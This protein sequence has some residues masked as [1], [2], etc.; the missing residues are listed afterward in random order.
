MVESV[1]RTLKRLSAD[2]D[3]PDRSARPGLLLEYVSTDWSPRVHP[4]YT[5]A[6][7]WARTCT[8]TRSNTL[9]TGRE[10]NKCV[11]MDMCSRGHIRF[12]S[13][14]FLV[15]RW[16]R[17]FP[18]SLYVSTSYSAAILLL[19]RS[20]SIFLKETT[21]DFGDI[22]SVSY[23]HR[24]AKPSFRWQLI[25]YYAH[26]SLSLSHVFI[27]ALS[28]SDSLMPPSFASRALR[29]LTFDRKSRIND[30]SV[31]QAPV[32][33]LHASSSSRIYLIHTPSSILFFSASLL[34][35]LW[36]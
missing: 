5:Q 15:C 6:L 21:G 9:R 17:S 36:F 7:S 32:L 22:C 20:F 25:A 18:Q 10:S 8:F 31:G 24:N 14:V 30:P 23:L 35:V 33:L 1:R 26:K 3:W 4:T 13:C 34:V 29:S 28:T 27:S 16:C 2:A 11:M 12:Y 19:R